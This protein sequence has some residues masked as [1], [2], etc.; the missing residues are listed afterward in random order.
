MESVGNPSTTAAAERGRCRTVLATGPG[1]GRH[2]ISR[3]RSSAIRPGRSPWASAGTA[4]GGGGAA[5]PDPR[6]PE[7]ARSTGTVGRTPQS[8]TTGR[9]TGGTE[10]VVT[11][12][13][14]DAGQRAIGPGRP[15]AAGP[16]GVLG[17]RQLGSADAAG[18]QRLAASAAGGA[19]WRLRRGTWHGPAAGRGDA[20]RCWTE[21]VDTSLAAGRRWLFGR[22]AASALRIAMRR[23]APS[24]SPSLADS[25]PRQRADT[26]G[27]GATAGARSVPSPAADGHCRRAAGACT[28]R[29]PRVVA[30]AARGGAA[31]IA[32]IGGPGAARRSRPDR[33]ARDAARGGRSLSIPGRDDAGRSGAAAARPTGSCNGPGGV[34]LSVAAGG[35][36]TRRHGPARGPGGGCPTRP[37]EPQG[38][39]VGAPPGN[40]RQHPFTR[41]ARDAA[42]TAAASADS[43][44]TR[45]RGRAGDPRPAVAW[46]G[47]TSP[48]PGT[49]AD[50]TAGAGRRWRARRAAC[51][52]LWLGAGG[53]GRLTRARVG[54]NAA[55]ADQHGGRRGPRRAAAVADQAVAALGGP[56]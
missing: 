25:R 14:A 56:R 1:R 5:M 36:S 2:R 52:V 43:G 44:S 30:A 49:V 18:V 33:V 41:P 38:A 15:R 50:R 6:T 13:R 32:T 31:L 51:A 26:D 40:G 22:S 46:R 35:R 29:G 42:A 7:A 20:G 54:R 53:V 17:R 27:R 10:W 4:S 37:R 3:A 21:A 39:C 12:G 11:A 34:P 9:N 19:L 47:G 45:C 48:V 24:P 23:P 28:R 8:I 55:A 16:C